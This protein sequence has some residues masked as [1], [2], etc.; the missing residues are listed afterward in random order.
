MKNRPFTW[1]GIEFPP[2]FREEISRTIEHASDDLVH[3]Y[4]RS[5]GFLAGGFRRNS[6]AGSST[7][8][9][10][11][12]QHLLAQEELDGKDAQFLHEAGLGQQFVIVLSREALDTLKE[13]FCGYFGWRPFTLALLLDPRSDVRELG[14]ELLNMPQ[15]QLPSQEE[16][17]RNITEC[18]A[19]FISHF[20]PICSLT[21]VTDA[22]QVRE[23]ERGV[24]TRRLAELERELRTKQRKIDE[25]TARLEEEREDAEAKLAGK[26]A[27]I[28]KLE[29]ENRALA[30]SVTATADENAGLK[31]ELE[32]LRAGMDAAVA[33]AVTD[34]LAKLTNGWLRTRVE[35]QQEALRRGE[36]SD[37]FA[38]AEEA[39][40]RQ[41]EADRHTGNL[42]EL[43]SRLARVRETITEIQRAR[44]S[45]LT[46]LPLLNDI[47]NELR[48]EE[49]RLTL[50]PGIEEDELSRVT[51]AL[52]AQISRAGSDEELDRFEVLLDEL[53]GL[54][55]PEREIR[56]L[57]QALD[58]RYD[59]LVAQ[60]TGRGRRIT[61]R[62]PASRLRTL[63]AEGEAVT[64]VCDG[65]NIINCLSRFEHVRHEGHARA[66]QALV[67]AL[68]P[69]AR[70]YP[71][72]AISIVFDGPDPNREMIADNLLVIYSGGDKNQRHRADERI[73]EILWGRNSQNAAPP[74][75]LVS[76]D[77]DLCR[78]ARSCG[79]G[80]IQLEQFARFLRAPQ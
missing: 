26:A 55:H 11:I 56:H 14:I 28:E 36:L 8:R 77:N 3:S 37:L 23:S 21:G 41:R 45:S 72:C 18:L 30:A 59:L 38:R 64:I 32:Q 27:R 76:D 57:R 1:D 70:D 53:T 35:A 17:A 7:F 61:P 80:V 79:A 67:D 2:E 51:L 46:P 54:G 49:R 78:E 9:K 65:H 12:T 16:A 69:L 15:D 44:T 48:A 5:H 47:E 25:L 60:H 33:A 74:H 31:R 68:A 29:H 75:F 50:I 63:L 71:R 19:P 43:R 20:L 66:R 22:G 34:E 58:Q 24:D 52:A 62:N 6:T 73:K 13:D 39:I 10:R 40:A 4:I 42:A